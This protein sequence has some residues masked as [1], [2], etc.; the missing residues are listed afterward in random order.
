MSGEP[1]SA[2]APTRWS[3][4]RHLALEPEG[5]SE[6]AWDE[7]WAYLCRT[8]RPAMLATVRSTLARIG[9]GVVRT[10]EAE[11]VVQSFLLSC[12]EKDY[13]ARA[14][15]AQGRFRSFVTV[16]LRR[17]TANYVAHRRRAKRA[18]TTPTL[19]LVDEADGSTDPATKEGW[20]ERFEKE[21]V[22]CL[23]DAALP[24]VEERSE[25]NARLLRILRDNPELD[26]ELLALQMNLKR[27]QVAVRRHRARKMLAEELWEIV[28]QTVSSPDELAEERAR[29]GDLLKVYVPATSAP[30]LFGK[31][32]VAE[33]S[34]PTRRPPGHWPR[35]LTS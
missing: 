33:P 29:L 17:H 13:L 8:F 23:L 32:P 30:S 26:E 27:S 24:R 28:K 10:G 14:D 7:A 34:K 18:P 35:S 1:F 31:K 15:E 6:A 5:P 21:W 2:S 3:R 19:T 25:P 9:G 12:L 16:C 4:I 11:D 22:S 20:D